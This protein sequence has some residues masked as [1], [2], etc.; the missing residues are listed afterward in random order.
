[1][2]WGMRKP[3]PA[4]NTPE[5]KEAGTRYI[6]SGKMAQENG[7]F[8]EFLRICDMLGGVVN[9]GEVKKERFKLIIAPLKVIDW[10][11]VPA[12]VYAIEE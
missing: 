6:E 7:E 1:R 10:G 4:P 9:C 2:E 8:F 12:T 5:A 11:F 3:R